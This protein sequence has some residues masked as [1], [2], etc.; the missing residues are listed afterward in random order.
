MHRNNFIIGVK[1]LLPV[2]LF[3]LLTL[4]VSGQLIRMQSILG[5][6][7]MMIG[8]QVEYTL[9]VDANSEVDF[10]LTPIRDTLS[11]VLEVLSLLSADTTVSEGRTVVEQHYLITGFESGS[12]IV[13]S[14]EVIYSRGGLSDTARS[15][16]LIINIYEPV[17]DTSQQ[18]R[19]IKPPINTPLSFKEVF[20]WAAAGLGTLLIVA[21]AVWLFLRFLKR[22]NDPDGYHAKALE[23]AHVIA[24]RE[25]DKLKEEKIW[26][27]GEVKQ[28]Y[29]C[30]TEIT[31]HYIERQYDIPAMESTTEEILHAF[32]K[33][34]PDDPLLDEML[35]ELLELAD[36]VK[37]AKEDPLPVDNQTNLNNAYLFVQ[38]TYPQFFHD[39]SDPNDFKQEEPGSSSEIKE[40][41]NG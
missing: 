2:G 22:K 37:F 40:L 41:G 34:N 23:P 28:Y 29:T 13:P 19:P 27:Q 3:L 38:K 5:S 26:T 21:L 4:P 12:Q 8:E 10:V 18:I 33:S 17:V 25:L 14:Q 6:D 39:E 35:K 36:L 16:P 30:L 24:F 9:R 15:M 32:R 1:D 31:R 7:S 11:A 20:P